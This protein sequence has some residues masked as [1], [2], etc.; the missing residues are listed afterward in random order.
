MNRVTLC[1]RLGADPEIK[2]IEREGKDPMDI[3]NFRMA[4][5]ERRTAASGEKSTHTEWHRI[6]AFGRNAEVAGAYLKKGRKVIVEGSLRTRTY[7][8]KDKVQ[9]R[10]TEIICSRIEFVDSAPKAD[11][12]PEPPEI[13]AENI[14]F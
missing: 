6:V 8:D 3:A 12:I 9:R 7:E 2:T 5:D 4:T 1:G 13:D 14:P 10:I 11:A